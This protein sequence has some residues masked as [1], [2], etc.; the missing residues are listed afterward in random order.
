MEKVIIFPDDVLIIKTSSKFPDIP[1]F[2]CIFA[3]G[4]KLKMEN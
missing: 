4:L 1:T 2:S 3:A